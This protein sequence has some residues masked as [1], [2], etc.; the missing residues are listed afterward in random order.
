[1]M[2]VFTWSPF[3]ILRLAI[4]FIV[5]LLVGD[6]LTVDFKKVAA[7]ACVFFICYLIS[8]WKNFKILAGISGSLVIVCLGWFHLYYSSPTVNPDHISNSTDWKM[9]GFIG[10]IIESKVEREEY[11]RYD[12]AVEQWIRGDSSGSISGLIHLYLAKGDS[13]ALEI[14]DKVYCND[15]F[16]RVAQPTNP[17]VFN[18]SEY[19]RRSGIYGQAFVRMDQLKI[20]SHQLPTKIPG[21]LMSVRRRCAEVLHLVITSD[22]EFQ[23]AEALILGIRD[24]LDEE[25]KSAYASVG[26]IHVLAVSGLH[27]G[28]I[29]MVLLFCLKPFRLLDHGNY[30]VF[31]GLIMGI[32]IF[33]LLTGNSPS[34]MRAATMFSIISLREISKKRANIYNT[35]GIAAMVILLLH[36]Q[37][38]FA[39]GFQL[40][41]IAVFGIVHLYPI[42]YSYVNFSHW[43]LDKVWSLS[44]VSMAAQVATFPL[45]VYYFSQFP[46]YFLVS[47]MFAIPGVTVALVMGFMAISAG[48]I[49]IELALIPGY[50]LDKAIFLV[51]EAIFFTNELPGSL[52][53]GLY[54][55]KV[56]VWLCYGVLILFFTGLQYRSFST[57][58]CTSVLLLLQLGLICD[59][60]RQV[61][62]Q[63]QVVFYDIPDKTT[64]DFIAGKEAQLIISN[65]RHEELGML[66]YQI[67]PYRRTIG[68]GSVSEGA[69]SWSESELVDDNEYF[70]LIQWQGMRIM[71]LDNPLKEYLA[72][73]GKLTVDVLVLSNDVIQNVSQL[74]ACLEAKK[75]ILS[76]EYSSWLVD[77]LLLQASK[78]DVEMHSLSKDGYWLLDLNKTQTL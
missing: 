57:F 36:P 34:V 59:R 75:V 30:I 61:V 45:S 5:G 41:F 25:V 14:G 65:Y 63:K 20:I 35:L 39:V 69:V 44:C 10:R 50:I 52:I 60:N 37:Y 23:I 11:L 13:I 54:I 56:E 4:W 46:V 73:D 27:V 22:R 66:S 67:D 1:M 6:S 3:P 2:Y 77:K 49:S 18:Y 42:I 24:Y 15:S 31:L 62:Y 55:S 71:I 78:H 53:T 17:A 19:L 74:P 16:R 43:L 68:L 48:F 64:I 29:Y 33:A 8:L 32:W 9:D 38:L 12:F 76:S 47:N 72:F 28:I 40:S 7:I 26:A 51:N 21:F 58:V 70:K